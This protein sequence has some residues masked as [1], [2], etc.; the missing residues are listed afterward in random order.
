MHRGL[1]RLGKEKDCGYIIELLYWSV[2]NQIV[3][4]KLNICPL[5]PGR[6]KKEKETLHEHDVQAMPSI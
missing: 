3:S 5:P 1:L 6:E 2:K 4:D